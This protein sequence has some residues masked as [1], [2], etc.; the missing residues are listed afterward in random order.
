M[1]LQALPTLMDEAAIRWQLK[2][3]RPADKLSYNFVVFALLDGA[4]VVLKLGVPDRELTSEIHALRSFGGRGAVRLI[5]GDSGRGM[6]LM[7]RLRPGSQLV[8]VDNDAEATQI[9]ADVMLSLLRPA[10]ADNGLLQIADWFQ[11]FQ[12]FRSK[13]GGGTGP[14]DGTLFKQAEKMAREILSEEHRPTLIHGDLHHFNILSS[15]GKWLAIDPKGVIGPAAYEVGPFLMNPLG[16]LTKRKDAPAL[17]ESRLSILTSM[18]GIQKD[19][20]RLC[21]ITH[22][23]LSAVWSIEE[24]GDWRPAMEVAE[25]LAGLN[26][27]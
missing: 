14:L 4:E 19:R 12:R 27:G 22:A 15:G 21:G 13:N 18:L 7:E 9:A 16:T 6:L 11:S 5:D 25:L 24:G 1:F 10:P 23:V 8:S 17:M 20:M 3:L 26:G 2:N